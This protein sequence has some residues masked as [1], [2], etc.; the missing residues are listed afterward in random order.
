MATAGLIWWISASW[1]FIGQDNTMRLSIFTILIVSL[2][3]SFALPARAAEIFFEAQSNQMRIGDEIQITLF[4]HTENEEI[5]ALEGLIIFPQE[6]LELKEIRDGNSFVK[7]WIERPRIET[8]LRQGFGGQ[9]GGEIIFSGITPGGYKSDKGFIFSII[10]Q[11][12]T[13]GEGTINFESVRVLKNDGQGTPVQVRI[14]P[15]QFVTSPSDGQASE[16][17]KQSLIAVI[18]DTEPPESFVPEIVS[19][20]TLFEGKQVLIFATQDKKSGIDHYEIKETRQ[21]FFTFV[22]KWFPAESPYVLKDPE[23]RSYVFVK[24]VDKAGNERE[25]KLE[26]RN[27]LVRYENYENWFIIILAIASLLTIKYVLWKK[28][29]KA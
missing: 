13:S 7:F 10:F 20:P 6:L 3:L 16:K 8:L 15:Y 27:P 26:P 19:T 14:S 9:A 5:N 2:S 21:R 4:L 29:K 1:R 12:K 11:A 17:Q 23:L 22:S 28:L 18:K 25:V 24:A